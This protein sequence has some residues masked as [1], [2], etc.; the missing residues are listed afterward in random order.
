MQR[1]GLLHG[2]LREHECEVGNADDAQIPYTS[3]CPAPLTALVVLSL[4]PS[5]PMLP[6]RRC[7]ADY[8]CRDPSSHSPRDWLHMLVDIRSSSPPVECSFGR[9]I[10]HISPS[11]RPRAVSCMHF[12]WCMVHIAY[13]DYRPCRTRAYAFDP[14]E[15]SSSDDRINCPTVR[16]GEPPRHTTAACAS[17]HCGISA[18]GLATK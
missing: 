10:A 15:H 7:A 14:S 9:G 5:L 1:D 18:L 8:G 16:V 17:C 13:T 11:V 6:D 4:C 2:V 12:P 3:P